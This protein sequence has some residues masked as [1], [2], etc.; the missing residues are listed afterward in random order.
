[1][2]ILGVRVHTLEIDQVIARIEEYLASG[3]PHHLVT[4]NPEFLVQAQA[5]PE[6]KAVLNQAD[7]AVAD[8]VGLV[9]AARMLGYGSLP[10]VPGV[11]LIEGLAA[12][13]RYRVFLL[14][15]WP[16]VAE[17][18]AAVLLERHPGLVIAGAY[19]GSPA[20]EEEKAII[21][22]VRSATPDVLLVAYGAPDQDLWIH[23]NLHALGV[24]LAAGV[25]GSFDFISGRVARA[26]GWMRRVGLEWLFRLITQPW[27]WRR[28]LRLPVF[29]WLVLQ[30]RMRREGSAAAHGS[31][32]SP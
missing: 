27:R 4:V 18:A 22:R 3:Q 29:A 2:N 6:F 20:R 1:M 14:G 7:L 26:P 10:R 13:R 8:G 19:A 15:G 12:L 16:G 17:A 11:D 5:L 21:A 30:Q 32:G 25:G 28:M 24:P 9:W 31:T 23:R